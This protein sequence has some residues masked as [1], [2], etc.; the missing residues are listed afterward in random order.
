[1]DEAYASRGSYVRELDRLIGRW[2]RR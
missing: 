1:V 2:T